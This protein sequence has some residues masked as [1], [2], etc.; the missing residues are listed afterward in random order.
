MERACITDAEVGLTGH[1]LFVKLERG[2]YVVTPG[3][4][5]LSGF[6]LWSV[7]REA[8]RVYALIVGA[9]RPSRLSRSCG[10]CLPSRLSAQA[11]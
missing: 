2:M 6:Y 8:K 4:V 5:F 10:F 1:R 3:G 7:L 9:A 11:A